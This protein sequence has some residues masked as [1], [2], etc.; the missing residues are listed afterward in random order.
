MSSSRSRLIA[1]VGIAAGIVTGILCAAAADAEVL[2]QGN[3]PGTYG[4]RFGPDGH[5]YVCSTAGLAVLDLAQGAMVDLIGPERGVVGPEDVIFGPDGAMYWAEMFTGEVGRMAPDGTVTR[6]A[7]G[8]MVN[9]LVF[10]PDGRLFVTEPWITDTL[11]QLDPALVDPPQQLAAGLGGLKNPEFGPDGLLYGALM[12]AGRVVRFD[13]DDPG[14]TTEVVADAIPGPFTARFGP[15]GMLYVVERSGFTIQRVDPTDGSRSTWAQLPFGPDNIAFAP[16]GAAFVTSYTDGVVAMVLPDGTVQELVPGGLTLPSGIAVRPRPDGESVFVGNLFSLREIDGATG[17]QLGV[18]RY[19]FPATGFGGAISVAGDDTD[20]ILTCFFPPGQARVQRWDPSAAAVVEE[21]TGFVTPVNA[22]PFAGDL[23]VVDLGLGPGEARVVLVGSGG[24]TVLADASDQIFAPLGLA[25]TDDELWVGDWA[26]GMIWQ[27]VAGGQAL[28]QPAPVAQG[29]A[30]PEGLAVDRDGS[31][32]VVEG[33]AGRV[34]RVRPETGAVIPLAS[35]LALS[36]EGF[37][38]LPPF[39]LLNGIAVGPSGAVYVAGDSGN[40]VYKLV[41]RTLYLPGAAHASGFKGSEWTT[42][43]ELHNRGGA[44]A[45]YTVELLVRGQ[46]NSAPAAVAFDLAPNTSVRYR[47]AVGSLFD[48]EGAATLRVTSVGGDL[49]ASAHT[50]TA[51][52]DGHYGQLIGS[53]DETDAAE[54]GTELRLIGL[55]GSAAARTNIGVVSACG[56]PITVDVRTHL[57]DGSPAGELQVEL[58]P[59]AS[60]QLND[61]FSS[62]GAAAAA[63]DLYAVVSS[64][65]PG[66]RFFAYASVVDNGT[67]DPIFIPGR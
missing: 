60:D 11:W 6:Q 18:E 12:W 20:L 36:L 41:P 4:L 61:V 59:F 21:V 35:G 56:V 52:G 28:P 29:L 26:T 47:D 65:T 53:F 25:A 57:A 39:A 51:E 14:A 44:G 31:L 66:A 67:N 13:V 7:I 63:D 8:P 2:A 54:P 49:L 3:L 45:S 55:E 42:D 17:A 62:L 27:L 16:T 34:S 37:G 33:T 19:R 5:L 1:N 22:I 23:V 10:S 40:L 58:A 46:A 43:L 64:Q 32:L 24:M 50:R 38:M 30:G 15:D 9:S 48:A